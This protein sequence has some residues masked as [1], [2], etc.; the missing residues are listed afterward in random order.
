MGP[1]YFPQ[2]FKENYVFQ[3]NAHEWNSSLSKNPG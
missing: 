2:N 1:E 3:G